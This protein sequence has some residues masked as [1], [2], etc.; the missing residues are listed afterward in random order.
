VTALIFWG[1]VIKTTK[2]KTPHII[3]P[4]YPGIIE[5]SLEAIGT[6]NRPETQ[7][8]QYF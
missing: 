2:G 8:L 5:I 3:P 4:K 7:Y 6:E 1:G